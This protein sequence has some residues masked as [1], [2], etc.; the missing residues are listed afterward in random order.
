LSKLNE[1]KLNNALDNLID[2]LWCD[3]LL[4]EWEGREIYDIPKWYNLDIVL[5]IWKNNSVK[6]VNYQNFVEKYIYK[7]SDEKIRENLLWKLSESEDFNLLYRNY[8]LWMVK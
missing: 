7:N 6:E 1:E 2:F 3:N 5:K 4:R 8:S